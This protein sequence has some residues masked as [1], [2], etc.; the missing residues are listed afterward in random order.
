MIQNANL[1]SVQVT[2]TKKYNV[3]ARVTLAYKC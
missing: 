1:N 2:F 3:F